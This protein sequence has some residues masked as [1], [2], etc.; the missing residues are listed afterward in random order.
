MTDSGE[1]SIYIKGGEGGSSALYLHADQGD[2]NNDQYRFIASDNDSIFLQNYASGNWENNLKAT[3]N[4][5]TILYY[6][7]VPK[8]ETTS[9]GSQISGALKTSGGGLSILTD[10]EKFTAGAGDDLQIYHDGTNSFITNDT[11]NLFIMGGGGH[12]YLQAVDNEN[13]VKVYPN[14]QVELYYDGGSPALATT[15]YGAKITGQLNLNAPSDYWSQASTYLPVSNLGAIGT[16]GGYE[17]T[18]TAG[19]YRRGNSEWHDYTINN[20]SGYAA[21][22]AVS[23]MNGNVTFRTQSGKSTGDSSGITTRLT[24]DSNG[25]LKVPDYV[26]GTNNSK[27]AFGGGFDL[28]IYHD[29]SNSYIDCPSSGVGHLIVRADDFYVKGSNDE[30][31]IVAHEN[32]SVGLYYNN[33]QKCQTTATGLSLNNNI[34]SWNEGGDI[35]DVDA[36]NIDHIWHDDGKNAFYFI[37]D[38]TLKQTTASAKLV[39]NSVVFGSNDPAAAA[40][41]LDDYEE[42]THTPGYANL[43]DSSHVTCNHFNYTKVGRLVHFNAKFTV[44]SSI[45]DT[46]GFGFSLPFTQAGSREIVASA[47]SDRSGTEKK[48]FMMRLHSAQ[49]TFYGFEME[50]GDYALYNDFSGSKIWVSGTYETT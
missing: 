35:S 10:S 25:L 46:S 26:S 3:G 24:I 11:G 2:D 49:S 5:S 28:Q 19:G 4:S 39:C 37:S 45:N 48:P 1:G 8:L 29:G 32:G 9:W 23:G 21:Q 40:N 22:V 17:F 14:A 42:G 43:N 12:C 38:G 31:M 50:G 6:D 13:G 30:T 44:S 41:R 16:H 20:Q 47:M 7:N 27:L 36:T 33:S 34:L 15:S 18:M